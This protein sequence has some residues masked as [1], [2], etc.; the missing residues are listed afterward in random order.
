[1]VVARQVAPAPDQSIACIVRAQTGDAAA[2][3]DL[4]QA[5]ERVIYNL[6]LGIVRNAEDA[7]DVVQDVWVRVARHL[8][9]LREPERFG[10]WLYRIARNCSMDF[11]KSRKSQPPVDRGRSDDED[12]PFDVPD[13]EQYAPEE[14]LLS[15]DERRKVW[16]AL[17]SLSEA[18][19]TVLYLRESRELPYSEVARILGVNRNAAEVRFFRARER[20]RRQFLRIEADTSTCYV[21]P[22]QLAALVSDELGDASRRMLE[23][24]VHS[25]EHC[26][27]RR[28]AMDKG[29][30]LYRGLAMLLVPPGATDALISNAPTMS[31]LTAVAGAGLTLVAQVASIVT[32][33]AAAVLVAATAVVS[34]V[35]TQMDAATAGAVT[36][37]QEQIG[38][39]A[40]AP[41]RFLGGAQDGTAG[42]PLVYLSEATAAVPTT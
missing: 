42:V 25:C 8:P 37:S 9:Q 27:S 14:Q 26:S 30:N 12:S 15:L 6:A 17:G 3:S 31:T 40:P 16:E 34:G 24:H 41:A 39:H 36:W 13:G 21:G 32:M 20:F 22:L 4:V 28:S 23:R 11:Y 29:R 7:A 1:V 33:K 2:F 18:D 38:S 10:P 19:R 5:H 35:G